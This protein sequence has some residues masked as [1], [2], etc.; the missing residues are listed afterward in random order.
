MGQYFLDISISIC[1][2]YLIAVVGSGAEQADD[3][4]DVVLPVA[5]VVH[6]LRG[7]VEAGHNLLL[8]WL[9]NIN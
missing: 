4:A 1:I 6:L 5:P 2:Y 7:Q 3:L 8:S 9:L